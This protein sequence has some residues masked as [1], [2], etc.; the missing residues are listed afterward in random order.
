MRTREAKQIQL[1]EMLS[2]KARCVYV[3]K[4]RGR[5]HTIIV[6]CDVASPKWYSYCIK[7]RRSNV[8]ALLCRTSVTFFRRPSNVSEQ[9]HQAKE[10]G[11]RS[12]GQCRGK[13]HSQDTFN[14]FMSICLFVYYFYFCI[15]LPIYISS[16]SFSLFFFKGNGN[17][18]YCHSRVQG[19]MVGHADANRKGSSPPR[20][21]KY[22]AYSMHFLAFF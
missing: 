13:R 5:C 20:C 16:L 11:C 4:R 17:V 9:S 12:T 10:V 3:R 6:Q 19:D 8:R 7:Y 21:T 22:V 14:G 15:I 2:K 18:W 1:G